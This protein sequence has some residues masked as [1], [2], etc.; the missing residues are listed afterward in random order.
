MG[1]PRTITSLQA[2]VSQAMASVPIE[3]HVHLS[4]AEAA[5][6]MA[7]NDIGASPVLLDNSARDLAGIISERDIV[8]SLADDGDPNDERVSD[9]MSVD[10]STVTPDTTIEVA[11]ELM[12]EGGMRHLPVVETVG[13]HRKVVG[14]ISVR[15]LLAAYRSVPE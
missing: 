1:N 15:D 10:L 7:E 11:T 8:R 13:G 3:I 2:P 4:I 6:L 14:M 12:L 9:W 5:A